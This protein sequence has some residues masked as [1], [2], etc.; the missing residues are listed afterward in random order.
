MFLQCSFL[1]NSGVSNMIITAARSLKWRLILATSAA[2]ALVIFIGGYLMYA[3]V[4]RGI[5]RAF[6]TYVESRA[7]ALGSL[8]EWVPEKQSVSFDFRGEAMPQFSRAKRP[9]YFEIY[10]ADGV[11]FTNSRSMGA[12]SLGGHMVT[13]PA[14]HAFSTV[15]RGRIPVQC[16][17]KR[18]Q[19]LMESTNAFTQP[20]E[21]IV[22]AGCDRRHVAGAS[23]DIL[24]DVI[25]GGMGLLCLS[26]LLIAL[27]VH[28]MLAPVR[29]F[30]RSLDRQNAEDLSQSYAPESVPSE[31]AAVVRVLNRL[32]LRIRETL[33]HEKQFTTSIAR[34]LRTPVAGIRARLEAACACR[35]DAQASR[36]ALEDA[37]D[38]VIG[39]QLLVDNLV[40]LARANAGQLDPRPAPTD[41]PALVEAVWRDLLPL[42]DRKQMRLSLAAEAT[43]WQTSAPCLRTI[44][45]NLL[46]NALSYGVPGTAVSVRITPRT[47]AVANEGPVL[48][49]EQWPRM[50]D[51]PWRG[52]AAPND[53][54]R[55][56]GIGLA[57]AQALAQVLGCTLSAAAATPPGMVFTLASPAGA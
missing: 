7:D 9:E 25:R 19:P 40:T 8:L 36:A 33:S 6:A 50:F 21:M 10:Y 16:V 28:T 2:I 15:V 32:L 20:P 3:D 17:V 13:N 48:S 45:G 42:A 43:V 41:M 54:G 23:A 18:L 46:D 26:A 34:E 4:R 51:L 11:L 37:R 44:V 5:E 57:V 49:P 31:F 12:E 29:A 52:D 30:A 47:L 24:H 39:V 1:Y 53:A 38:Q 14:V 27:I 55:H 35:Q 22:V 56:A